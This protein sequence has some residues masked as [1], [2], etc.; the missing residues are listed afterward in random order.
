MTQLDWTALGRSPE[1]EPSVL[2]DGVVWRYYQR[3]YGNA[4]CRNGDR[5]HGTA[6]EI[7][8]ANGSQHDGLG[9]PWI[10]LNRGH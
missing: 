1:A 5:A 2:G 9:F 6:A 8:R 10:G 4:C 3:E 7:F